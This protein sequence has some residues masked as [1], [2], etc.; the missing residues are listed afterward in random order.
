MDFVAEIE[1]P[2]LPDGVAVPPEP[3]VPEGIRLSVTNGGTVNWPALARETQTKLDVKNGLPEEE[4]VMYTSADGSPP[5]HWTVTPSVR[6]T[7]AI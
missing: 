5:L 4:P 6:E 7:V 2:K 3:F 1:I